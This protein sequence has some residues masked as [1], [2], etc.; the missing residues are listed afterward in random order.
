MQT[1]TILEVERQ[2]PYPRPVIFRAFTE[3]KALAQWF[4]PTGWHVIPESVELDPQLGG[5]LRH[6]KV[7]DDDPDAHWVVDGVYTE[8]FYPDVLVT[9]QRITGVKGIDASRPVELRV[10]FTKL[11]RNEN[12]TLVR[13][14]QG[15]YE[16][17]VASWHGTAWEA[18]L[19]RLADYLATTNQEAGR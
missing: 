5:R 6:T 3:P 18:E 14:I 19:T 15:P 10:E 17:D 1:D 7:R 9:R 16:A 8:V 4:A 2:F 11:G 13:I 12:L